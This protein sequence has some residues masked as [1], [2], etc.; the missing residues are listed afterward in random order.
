MRRDSPTEKDTKA[1][2]RLVHT[3]LLAIAA[4][5]VATIDSPET[6][7]AIVASDPPS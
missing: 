4:N 2:D 3:G 1:S 7:A 5:T 6:Q